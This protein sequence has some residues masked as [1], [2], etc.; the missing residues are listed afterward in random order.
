MIMMTVIEN[1]H[2]TRPSWLLLTLPFLVLVILNWRGEN[3]GNA[4]AKK[5]PKH[6]LKAL[7]VGDSNWNSRI[8]IKTLSVLGIMAILVASGPSWY[9]QALPFG[10]ST[11]P[12]VIVLDVSNSMQ[13][14][15]LAPSRL[16]RAKQ[17]IL[18]LIELRQSGTTALIVYSGSA[19]MAMPLTQDIE[20]FRPLLESISAEVMPRDGKFAEY[21]LA[22]IEQV[23]PENSNNATVLL[24]TDA[25]NQ[26]AFNEYQ[27]YFGVKPYQLLV[28]GI[29]D[30][31]I[32]TPYPLESRTLSSLA[33]LTGGEFVTFTQ[34][35]G[36]IKRLNREIISFSELSG[37]EFEP[38]HD[39]GY[40][41]VWFIIVPYLLW[42]RKGWLVKW[43]LVF[44][45]CNASL[46]PSPVYASELNWLDVWLT[47]DQ[48]GALHYDRAEY[49]SA[50]ELFE[51]ENWKAESYY[52]VGDYETA[53]Q[54][55]MR[56]DDVA[57]LLGAAASLAH[58]KEYIAAKKLYEEIL[59]IDPSNKVAGNNL[60]VVTSVIEHIDTFT[61]SQS[62][63]NEQQSSK[64]RGDKPK[65]SEGILQEIDK[66]QL[67]QESLSAKDILNNPVMNEKW[68][69]RVE[70]DLANF[71]ATK[72]HLQLEQGKG[73]STEWRDE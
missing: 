42:F 59:Q 8:P 51:N 58:M 47:R 41:L 69:K 40:P 44:L 25:V 9:R 28:Y 54:Y 26:K 48:Q 3:R 53:Q 19:H 29:G 17:K 45:V 24:V 32:T 64:E 10:E 36:D 1:F 13:Q 39:A 16:F 7:Q 37:G 46:F 20:V 14:Q 61:Q 49:T 15:D 72:F 70:S 60:Q 35:Q 27:D 5:L 55:Y 30:E 12:L 6:L 4:W 33:R 21:T 11:T 57:S 23:L 62:N 22:V 50:A 68:M 43:S 52:L 67:I 38:W 34:E 2:F 65:S 73:R 63:S 71:L 66:K 31:A 18:S 56:N